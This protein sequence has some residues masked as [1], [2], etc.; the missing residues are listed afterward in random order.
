MFVAVTAGF[1]FGYM[2]GLV[3]APG[4][5]LAIAIGCAMTFG[6]IVVALFLFSPEPPDEYASGFARTEDDVRQA[7]ADSEARKK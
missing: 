6:A 2:L 4:I 1:V 7:L 5:A 3:I